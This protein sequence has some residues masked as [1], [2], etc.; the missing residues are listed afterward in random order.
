MELQDFYSE[1]GDPS[2]TGYLMTDNPSNS[3]V[4]NN[5]RPVTR[6]VLGD[7]SLNY[8]DILNRA[9]SDNI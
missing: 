6:E 5:R 2:L 4:S 7:I 9:D 8:F 1:A 3:K